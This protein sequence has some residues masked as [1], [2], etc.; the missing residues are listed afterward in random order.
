MSDALE[1]WR[2]RWAR[3]GVPTIPLR[4]NGKRPVSDDWKVE[5]PDEQWAQVGEDFRGNIGI[6]T[7]NGVVV[8]DADDAPTVASVRA[9]LAGMGLDPPVVRTAG[10]RHPGGRHLYLRVR[11]V[12]PELGWRALVPS[13][14]KGEVSLH[15]NVVAPCSAIGGNRYVFERGSVE[16]IAALPFVLWRDMAWLLTVA[17]APGQSFWHPPVRLLH[18][19]LPPM[20]DELLS[21]LRTAQRG[22]PVVLVDRATGQLGYRYASRSEAE[23]AV[24]AQLILAGLSCR[25]SLAVFNAYEPGHFREKGRAREQ[26]FRLCYNRAL[27]AI[28][29]VPERLAIA[30]EWE[31]AEGMA[32]SGRGG[33]GDRAVYLALL[34]VAWQCGSWQ[35]AA[36]VRDLAEHA[37]L[38][39]QGASNALHRLERRGLITLLE[40][41]HGGRAQRVDVQGASKVDIGHRYRGTSASE[42]VGGSGVAAAG[43][44]SVATVHGMQELW[45]AGR[46]GMGKSAEL[47]YGHLGAEPVSVAE[48]ATATGKSRRTVE[49]ALGVLAG[50][51]LAQHVDA[52]WVRGKNTLM[53]LAEVGKVRERERDRRASH[54][55]QREAW[56]DAIGRRDDRRDDP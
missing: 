14:G 50:Q 5:T 56:R 40:P 11:N 21:V 28:C 19:G 7:G 39:V 47:V 10:I 12:P 34:A 30:H 46:D 27:N 2:M 52:G 29:N 22:V 9:G 54:Q 16:E 51:D 32:W 45:A 15:G 38:S 1:T 13:L 31:S 35:V 20:A 43:A 26:Y 53:F 37:A 36:S 4:S 8:V 6:L 44:R 42:D 23:Q 48:L 55:R 3:A 17:V 41:A 49:R 18:R 33:A 25:E 24:I